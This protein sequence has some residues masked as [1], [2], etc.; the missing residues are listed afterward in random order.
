MVACRLGG[1][2]CCNTGSNGDV[3]EKALI[4][5]FVG[6][7]ASRKSCVRRS[8]FY[9]D[10]RSSVQGDVFECLVDAFLHR[11]Y[12]QKRFE[13]GGVGNFWHE[14]FPVHI[15]ARNRV[16][17]MFRRASREP[18]SVSSE[19]LANGVIYGIKFT[20]VATKGESQPNL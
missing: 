1:T 16:T 15:L 4:F 18:H 14:R 2:L 9:T 20:K 3:L 6:F 11:N 10:R 13:G 7:S 12:S 5:L 19:I 8:H 17:T